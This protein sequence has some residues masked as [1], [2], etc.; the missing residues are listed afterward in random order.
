MFKKYALAAA[1][2][3]LLGVQTGHAATATVSISGGGL[4]VSATVNSS[5]AAAQTAAV[6]F[7]NITSLATAVNA[8]GTVLVTCDAGTPF[9]LGLGLGNNA[10]GT[11][12]RMAFGFPATFLPYKLYIDNA[13]TFEYTDIVVGTS[14]LNAPASST[15]GGIGAA[16]GQTF[17]V[18]GVI[19][20]GTPK[21]APGT[22]GDSVAIDVGY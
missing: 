5:C 6:A 17:S 11:Q 4:A 14:T 19:A 12:R 1:A 3:V 9:A 21:P 15:P 10:S 13:H 7:P 22:Y 8:T 2:F 20:A 18:F 16:G